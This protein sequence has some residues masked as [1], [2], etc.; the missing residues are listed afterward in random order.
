M[1]GLS[2]ITTTVFSHKTKDK[3]SNMLETVA[4][5]IVS[6][7]ITVPIMYSVGA[8]YMKDYEQMFMEM[9]V[10]SLVH[11][12]V[13]CRILERNATARNIGT[14]ALFAVVMGVISCVSLYLMHD[15][16]R[17]M[18]KKKI[19]GGSDWNNIKGRYETCV[20]EDLYVEKVRHIMQGFVLP[21]T[22]VIGT[23]ETKLFESICIV[24]AGI[25][26]EVAYN[27]DDNEIFL[28]VNGG[29]ALIHQQKSSSRRCSELHSFFGVIGISST[30]TSY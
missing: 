29:V 3:V 24:N 23:L 2:T 20:P 30:D 8:N 26:L 7:M 28:S 14:A 22:D 10:I 25:V 19:V 18:M 6:L 13:L 9:G 4:I 21:I 27:L 15:Y 1:V 16:E 12:K 5:V 17:N 11:S